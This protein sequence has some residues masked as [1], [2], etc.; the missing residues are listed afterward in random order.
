MAAAQGTCPSERSRCPSP[1]QTGR[2]QGSPPPHTQSRLQDLR[3]MRSYGKSCLHMSPPTGRPTPQDASPRA[4]NL[5]LVLGEQL[6]AAE[7][8][9]VPGEGDHRLGELPQ[10]QLQQ[11]GHRVHICG[12]VGR[13]TCVRPRHQGTTGETSACPIPLRGSLC[14][15]VCV[16]THTPA[17]Y[18]DGHLPLAWCLPQGI[19]KSNLELLHTAG[20]G[21]KGTAVL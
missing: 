7:E 18:C 2:F 12:A 15:H 11:G 5:P 6:G 1:P 20:W 13:G 4:T 19:L 21:A 17:L 8:V 14:S 9:L 10:V 16:H 3:A